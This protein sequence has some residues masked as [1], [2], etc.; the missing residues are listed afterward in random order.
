ME[1]SLYSNL[2]IDDAMLDDKSNNEYDSDSY[3][4]KEDNIPKRKNSFDSKNTFQHY[5]YL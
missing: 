4:I 1:P 5:K 2:R 3:F